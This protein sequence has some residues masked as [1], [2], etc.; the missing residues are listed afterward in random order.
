[1]KITRNPLQAFV[2][3]LLCPGWGQV[4]VGRIK[5]GLCVPALIYLVALLLGG[6]GLI[7]SPK[8]VY[9]FISLITAIKL[10]SAIAAAVQVRRCCGFLDVPGIRSHVIYVVLVY[11]AVA[12][13]L[14]VFRG[15][16][17]GYQIYFVPSGSMA[18]TVSVGD[19]IVSDTRV[20]LLEIGDIVV[21]RYNG[22][23]AVKRVAGIAGDTLAIVDGELIRNGEN[24]GFFHA[25]VNR[26]K[27]DF[28]RQLAPLN[29]KSGHVY[30]LGDNRDVSNDSRF[31]GQVT[32]E[33][34]TGRVTGIFYSEDRSRIG[35]DF[36]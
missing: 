35:V 12:M 7:A 6:G 22:V 29:V 25:S 18:P 31:V 11:L 3:S 8:G 9:V 5:L 23:E 32:I 26:V 21:Y 27:Y 2:M 10:V 4:Y 19:Y 30:L 24:L 17:L 20:G 33:N 13:L 34:I 16:L 15:S 28:S 1:M 14:V 36:P